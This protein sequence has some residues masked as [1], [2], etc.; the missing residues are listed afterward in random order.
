MSKIILGDCLEV[1]RGFADNQFDLVLTDPPYG[2]NYTVQHNKMADSNRTSAR[3]GYWKRY[4][5]TDW[6]T[7]APTK[8]Y[9]DE[10]FRVS[11][12]QIIWG[13]QYFPLSS[14]GG[15]L[16]WNKIQ[17]GFMSDGEMA[18]TNLAPSSCKIFDYSRADA[19]INDR[20]GKFHP[21]QK[22][23]KLMRWCLSIF[24]DAKTVLDPFMGSGTTTRAC[25]D[26]G[27]ECTGIEINPEY[28]KIAEQRLRQEVLL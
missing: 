13:G 1:M 28:V 2:I 10:I 21:A 6:D 14:K 8:E 26:L 11:K 16:I 5:D 25:K 18:W 12:N 23:L 20:D 7:A 9:F 24:P 19:Y 15:W 3:G 22:P 17:R 4:K 27:V